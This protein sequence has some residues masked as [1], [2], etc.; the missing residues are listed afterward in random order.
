MAIDAYESAVRTMT[1]LAPELILLLAAMVMMTLS[2]FLQP[3]DAGPGAASPSG[4]SW[5]R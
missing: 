4:R 2:A 3:A 5:P 1:I